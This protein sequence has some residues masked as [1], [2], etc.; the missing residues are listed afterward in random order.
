MTALDASQI[1]RQLRTAWLGHH[2]EIHP[3]LPSTQDRARQL[4]HDGAPE[5]AVVVAEEQTAGRGRMGRTWD[6]PAGSS[7]LLSILLR[8]PIAPAYG[9]L[10]TAACS[11]AVLDAAEALFGLRLSVK[12]PN[13][14]IVPPGE[15][16]IAGARYRKLAG[17]LTETATVGDRLSYCTVGIGINCNLDPAVLPSPL[18]APAS[19][20]AELGRPI[21]RASLLCHLL[22]HTERRYTTLTDPTSADGVD[23]IRDEWMARMATLGQPVTV[24]GGDWQLQGTAESVDTFGALVVRDLAGR[25]HTVHAADVTLRPT[26]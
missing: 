8:P 19:L 1:L 23:S 18:V 24:N 6:A 2:L 11:L 13:D 25:L 22:L 15:P 3:R 10:I 20:S 5:G 26:P 21:D 17:I 9:A 16:P 7:L 4:A 12:W 14:I